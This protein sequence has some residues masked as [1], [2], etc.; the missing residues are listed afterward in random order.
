M[1][2][3]AGQNWTWAGMWLEKKR[4]AKRT[5]QRWGQRKREMKLS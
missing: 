1:L 5:G 2:E 3:G 4:S